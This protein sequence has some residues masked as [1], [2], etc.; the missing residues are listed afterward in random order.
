MAI[1][2]DSCIENYPDRNVPTVFVYRNGEVTAN[3]VGLA[4]FGGQRATLECE[5]ACSAL[6]Q[7]ILVCAC[8]HCHGLCF[9]P[10]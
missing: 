7:R 3:I 1:V 5:R 6:Q 4:E 9:P 8:I 2:S 10:Y